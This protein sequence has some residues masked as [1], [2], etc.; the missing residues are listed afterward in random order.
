MG[1]L[2]SLSGVFMIF[3]GVKTAGSTQVLLA[4]GLIPI[5]MVLSY[6]MLKIR[7]A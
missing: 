3:G 4:Q 7:S 2:D 1:A 6:V 5:T